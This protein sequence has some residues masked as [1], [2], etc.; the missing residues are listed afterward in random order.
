MHACDVRYKKLFTPPIEM[1]RQPQRPKKLPNFQELSLYVHVACTRNEFSSTTGRDRV[2]GVESVDMTK[3]GFIPMQIE[4]D[5]S[6]RPLT[7]LIINERSVKQLYGFFTIYLAACNCSVV[8][9]Q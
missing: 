6:E 8:M 5:Y 9:V 2:V 7:R 1:K 4:S 3:L